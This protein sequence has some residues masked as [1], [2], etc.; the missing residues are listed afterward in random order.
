MDQD[1]FVRTSMCLQNEFAQSVTQ[2]RFVR[3]FF[4][5]DSLHSHSFAV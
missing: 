1:K 4:V 5:F 3:I 2:F